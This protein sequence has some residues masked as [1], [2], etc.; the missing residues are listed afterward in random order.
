MEEELIHCVCV[1]F[2]NDFFFF[3]HRHL[4]SDPISL[5]ALQDQVLQPQDV[6]KTDVRYCERLKLGHKQ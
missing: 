6:S 4:L 5:L 1:C 2:V 3:N